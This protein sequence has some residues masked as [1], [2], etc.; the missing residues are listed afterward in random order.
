MMEVETIAYDDDGRINAE[1]IITFDDTEIVVVEYEYVDE[2]RVWERD[3]GD[4]DPHTR[5]DNK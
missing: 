4:E 2:H 5:I 1:T 3:I